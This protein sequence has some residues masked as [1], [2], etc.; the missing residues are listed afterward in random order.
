VEPGIIVLMTIRTATKKPIT[1]RLVQWTGNNVDEVRG[2]TGAVLFH[3]VDHVED[4]FTAEVFDE[5]HCS[6]VLVKTGQW[7]IEGVHGE[8][9]PID[10]QVLAD[11]YVLEPA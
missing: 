4:E 11:T 10:E 2:L 1:V 9:Y 8:F 3:P 7:I 5:L 6:W